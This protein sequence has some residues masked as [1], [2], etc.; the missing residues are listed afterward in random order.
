MATI[1]GKINLSSLKH[2]IEKRKGKNGEITSLVIPIE[3]NHLFLSE[4]G[5]CYL[6][7]IAFDLKN[8]KDNQTHIL[9]QSFSKEVREKFTEEEN[10]NRPPLGSLNTNAFS[11]EQSSIPEGSGI[12]IQEGDE[13]PF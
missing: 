7:V 3:A 2:V 1:V 12:V 4:K 10:K 8:P 13:L 5:N 9:N 6:D 11:G